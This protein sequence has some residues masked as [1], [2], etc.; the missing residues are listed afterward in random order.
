MKIK[1]YKAFNY[2]RAVNGE[3]IYYVIKK[4][5]WFLVF[6]YWSKKMFEGNFPN[7]YAKTLSEANQLIK[8]LQ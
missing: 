1:K 5:K 8:I 3:I 6:P 7:C 2:V 4:R